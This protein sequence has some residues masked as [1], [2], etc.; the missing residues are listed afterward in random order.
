MGKIAIVKL[1]DGSFEQGFTVTLQIASEG[2]RPHISR[3]G[4]L[5]PAPKIPQHYQ[6]WQKVYRSHTSG[7]RISKDGLEA[8]IT[9]MLQH[10]PKHS[11]N[12]LHKD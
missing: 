12:L 6:H 5:P 11:L 3:D 7:M 1:G 9:D 4:N 10:K 8:Q 2:L